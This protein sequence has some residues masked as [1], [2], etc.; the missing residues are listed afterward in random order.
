MLVRAEEGA[1]FNPLTCLALVS[2]LRDAPAK[3]QNRDV[4]GI[5][6]RDISASENQMARQEELQ[7]SLHLAYGER[8]HCFQKQPSSA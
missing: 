6:W 1:E 8:S 2:T 4:S 5:G 3:A 7:P